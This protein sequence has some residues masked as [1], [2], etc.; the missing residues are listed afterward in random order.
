MKRIILGLL[1]SLWSTL[2]SAGIPCTLPFTLVNGVTADATQV[3]ANY[4][5]LVACLARAAT[6]GAN[7]DITSLLGLT[8]PLTPAG[9]GTQWFIGGTSTGSANA[10]VISSLTPSGFNLT[11]NTFVVFSAGFTNNAAT[12]WA[13]NGTT[14]TAVKVHTTT[15]LAALSGGEIVAG[16]VTLGFF[17]GTQYQLVDAAPSAS[18]VQPC[19]IIDYGGAVLPT[20]YLAANGSTFSRTSFPNLAACITVNGVAATTSSGSASVVVPNSALFQVGWSVG[21]NNVTCNSTISTIPDSTHITISPNAG[22]NGGATTLTIGPYSQGDCSTTL[23]L[24]PLQ[25]R[26]TMMA[27]ASGT[28]LTSTTCTNPAS[29]GSNCGAQTQTLTP[30][31]IPNLSATGSNSLTSIQT[32]VIQGTLQGA[33]SG[34][35][36]TA[37][38]SGTGVSSTITVSGLVTVNTSNTGGAA[39]PILPPVGL[40]NKA[41]KF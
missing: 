2:A 8:T 14:A 32:N 27:D 7:S 13:V 3:M 30:S 33:S 20:G 15:G 18:L 29:V 22:G 34:A 1:L 16:Q 39:H 25:G 12:T 17:D 41:I 11:P 31:Q 4:N 21:G 10:Q 28:V 38:Q 26:A 24:P 37:L 23:G 35:G 6:A 36:Q 9:G 19:T 5:A 40:V